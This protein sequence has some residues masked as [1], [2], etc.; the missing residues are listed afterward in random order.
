MTRRSNRPRSSAYL[1]P[2][3]AG[4]VGV[5]L[6]DEH[7][8]PSVA[9]DTTGRLVVDHRDLVGVDADFQISWCSLVSTPSARSSGV[10]EPLAT[11]TRPISSPRK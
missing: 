6:G 10:N 3:A 7:Q 2:V 11:S 5:G 8:E 4:R 1:V 9:E